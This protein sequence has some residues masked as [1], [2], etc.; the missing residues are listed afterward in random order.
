MTI[1]KD[2][3]LSFI[4]RVEA[5]TEEMKTFADDIKDV[6][7]EAKSAGYDAKALRAIVKRRK[8]PDKYA[9]HE[10]L[11]ESYIAALGW[12]KTPLG[13]SISEGVTVQ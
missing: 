11:V 10:A 8:D 12:D 7:S 13:G 1:T 9:E 5:L 3:L 2:Q 4:R 6:Y